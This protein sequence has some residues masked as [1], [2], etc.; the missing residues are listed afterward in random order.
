MRV[1]KALALVAVSVAAYPAF[2]ETIDAGR[3]DVPLTVPEG[4]AKDSPAP[5]VLL[6][7]G[8]TS[9][10]K[11]QESYMK[12][13][14]LADEYGFLFLTP[15]GTV[16][17]GGDEHQFWNATQACCNFYESEVDDS[18]YLLGLIKETKKQYNVD[19]DRIYLIGHSNGGF[20]SHRMAYDH[21]EII[22]AIASLA[23]AAIPD[24][25]GDAPKRPVNILQIHGTKDTVIDY[26]GG[27]IN[28]VDY[29]SAV[30]TSLLWLEYNGFDIGKMGLVDKLDLDRRIEGEDTTVTEYAENGAV[31]LWTINDGSHIPAIS[32][33][34]TRLVI[35]WL[36][37]HPKSGK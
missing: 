34:F 9:S 25:N 14:K 16:E 28:D 1:L 3:G 35:E 36:L 32:E 33:D 10:G 5:L 12:F 37:A 31:E 23:G 2:A 17:G 13:G 22:A 6:L 21:P 8:Y 27:D 15:D 20:M 11:Q 7:H 29:P 24:M 4:Y 18:G 19:P 26:E 30:E